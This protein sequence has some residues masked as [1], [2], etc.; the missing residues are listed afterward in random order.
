LLSQNELKFPFKL[1]NIFSVAFA[2]GFTIVSHYVKYMIWM[3]LLDTNIKN[4]WQKIYVDKQNINECKKKSFANKYCDDLEYCKW[5]ARWNTNLYWLVL[6][7]SDGNLHLS[8]MNS[9]NQTESATFSI[10]TMPFFL[11]FCDMYYGNIAFF[12]STVTLWR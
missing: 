6:E 8:S 3:T 2:N 12:S 1:P 4:G 9:L 5:F 10:F 11:K 7:G